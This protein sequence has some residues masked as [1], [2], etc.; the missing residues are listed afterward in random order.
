MPM[1]HSSYICMPLTINDQIKYDTIIEN[2]NSQGS[3]KM[4][5]S[6]KERNYT[7]P[8]R[9]YFSA[10]VNK[11]SYLRATGQR[12]RNYSVHDETG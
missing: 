8:I 3:L 10:V 7:H 6:A 9:L 5:N 11:I 12:F 4:T 2:L 1:N